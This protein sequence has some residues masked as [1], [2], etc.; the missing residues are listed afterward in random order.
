MNFYFLN[1]FSFNNHEVQKG[2]GK[3]EKYIPSTFQGEEKKEILFNHG[4]ATYF[5]NKK[6]KT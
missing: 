6:I 1:C 3:S 2:K 5:L 4:L